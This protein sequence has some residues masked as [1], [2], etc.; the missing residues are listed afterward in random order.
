MNE[1][2]L[3]LEACA[4]LKNDPGRVALATIVKVQGS[5]YRGPGA[6]LL[7]ASDG[8]TVGSISAGCLEVDLCERARKVT[9]SGAPTVVTYDTTALGDN[10]WG[11]GL[12]CGG[13]IEVLIE[14]FIPDAAATPLLAFL[15]ERL[16]RRDAGVVVTVFRGSGGTTAIGSRLAL[17]ASGPG[18]C[19]IVDPRLAEA[20]LGEA[21]AALHEG[22]SRVKECT[23]GEATAEAL[24]EVVWPPLPLVIF[25]A[26][27]DAV[28]L[29]R[30]ANQVGWH[31][32]VV[33]SRPGLV[34]AERFPWADAVVVSRPGAPAPG[35]SLDDRT[36]VVVMT[37]NFSHDR[38]LVE[39]LLPSP[40]RY[41][42]VLGARSRTMAMLQALTEKG[43]AVRDQNLARL[44]S[45]VGLDLGAETPEEIAL[46]IL[47]EIKAVSKGRAAGFLRDRK[48]PIHDWMETTGRN[49]S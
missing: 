45:P 13:T 23:A 17:T 25:G 41:L 48:G 30:L 6:R 2:K 40:I 15:G 33:D 47:A 34:T 18:F 31:V 28:P 32:T 22:R 42:G 7:I 4:T 11:L 21:R 9:A 1:I 39:M 20:L 16:A 36:V 49:P 44:Y 19:D 3:L 29:A 46:A 37:H 26:G 10:V 12:G 8:R 35:V 24:I 14:P 5:A 38:E 43:L 27:D